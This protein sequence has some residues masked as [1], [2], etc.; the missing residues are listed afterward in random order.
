MQLTITFPDEALLF[1]LGGPL[2]ES[3][4]TGEIKALD[5]VPEPGIEPGC[6]CGR[7]ILSPFFWLS[8]SFPKPQIIVRKLLTFKELM[9]I[10]LIKG[11]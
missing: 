10:L 7:R 8:H 9:L 11:R 5:M 2:L 1:S 4:K 6:P 3:P